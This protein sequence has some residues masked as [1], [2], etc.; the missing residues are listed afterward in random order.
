[1]GKRLPEG[2]PG[3]DAARAHAAGDFERALVLARQ[4][5]ALVGNS[6][7][8]E[9][10]EALRRLGL[11]EYELAMWREAREHLGES[12]RAHRADGTDRLALSHALDDLG[13]CCLGQ[14]E[15]AVAARH[16]QEALTLRRAQPGRADAL[17]AQSLS[18]LALIQQA[19]H[20]FAGAQALLEEALALETAA[21]VD[22]A[23][24]GTTVGNLSVLEHERGDYEA[25]FRHGEL[26]LELHLAALGPAHPTVARD[27]HNLAL[28]QSAL[29]DH[30]GA[31]ARLE[32]AL[33]VRRSCLGAEHPEVVNSQDALAAVLVAAGDYRAVEELARQ[34]F[35]SV[36]AS[37]EMP[38]ETGGRLLANL[39]HHLHQLGRPDEAVEVNTRALAVLETAS[40]RQ[41]VLRCQ[42]LGNLGNVLAD[43]DRQ[44]EAEECY[45]GG[46]EA[47]DACWP[48]PSVHRG[49]IWL[50]LANLRYSRGELAGALDALDEADRQFAC[51]HRVGSGPRLAVASSRAAILADL[52][53]RDE[54][55]RLY[56]QVVRSR[57]LGAE[58]HPDLGRDLCQLAALLQ[59]LDQLDEAERLLEEACEIFEAAL[60]GDHLAL[61]DALLY[62]AALHQRRGRFGAAQGAAARAAAVR[63]AVLGEGHPE[64]TEVLALEA[65]LHEQL[66]D[67]DACVAIRRRLLSQMEGR[68]VQ[69]DPERV[70]HLGQ[71]ADLQLETGELEAA[72]AT[73]QARIALCRRLH[74]PTDP[75]TA[76]A[77]HQHAVVCLA[78]GDADAAGL[79]A[80]EACRLLA[81]QLGAG[82]GDA[83]SALETQALAAADGGD[84][85]S[86]T[87]LLERLVRGLEETRGRWCPEI[88][89]P[90]INLALLEAARDAP[91]AAFGYLRE[92]VAVS[93]RVRLDVFS[94]AS[95]ALRAAHIAELR[96]AWVTWLRLLAL[97]PRVDP[98][99]MREA[100]ELTMRR[101][102]IGLESLRL[103]QAALG[104]RTELAPAAAAYEGVRR[105]LAEL[106]LAQAPEAELAALAAERD[107][108]EMDLARQIPG[109][110]LAAR[111]DA[112]TLEAVQAALPP[113]SALVEYV[114]TGDEDGRLLAFCL[115]EQL[116]FH[117][118][119]PMPDVETQITALRRDLQ[120]RLAGED[121]RRAIDSMAR[122][123]WDQLIGPLE[124]ALGDVE[125]LFVSAD[126][127]LGLLPFA[128]LRSPSGDSLLDRWLLVGINGPRD[129]LRFSE[130]SERPT[131]QALV[132][133][134]PDFGR[135]GDL[136]RL[137]RTAE[138]AASVAALVGGACWL[139]GDALKGRVRRV[140]GP[141]ILHIASHGIFDAPQPAHGGRWRHTAA[142][143]PEPGAMMRSGI[144]L[145][146]ANGWR[147]GQP[148]SGDVED[149]ILRAEDV[150]S[151]NL[152]STQL[153][154]LSA[155]DSGVGD[156]LV[157][158]GVFGLRR[159]VMAAGAS[160]L[161]MT[162]WR[163]ADEAARMFMEHLYA[164]L[165]AGVPRPAAL[166][167]A[168]LA[169]RAELDEPAVWGAFTYLGRPDSL[170]VPG[171]RE[172]LRPPLPLASPRAR[173]R[174]IRASSR[175]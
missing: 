67:L 78:A 40:E 99:V 7:G 171:P 109:L 133:A 168:Q 153:V 125:Q 121:R 58:A 145:A 147:P 142:P 115:R 111:L 22:A 175:G 52:G 42:V 27:L 61:A 104:E 116:T 126:G 130:V 15:L 14:G 118:L 26:A 160:G 91:E 38:A 141:W 131:T 77:I 124:G 81:Q 155:C 24:R 93:E 86:A 156:V 117:D 166:R 138:E 167:Q 3:D 44:T 64:V 35:A 5:L 170:T 31:R 114:S 123:L 122:A 21:G 161:V 105:R 39:A 150:I 65:S 102:A 54:A 95:D 96:L 136:E 146:G 47:A 143:A 128:V 59:E 48:D 36:E 51:G 110:A 53:R 41:P 34:I 70:A 33:A 107:A 89:D 132:V 32:R 50:G 152:R 165:L 103:R 62:L 29:G 137:P 11:I 76:Q 69:T 37:R 85:D 100:F 10:A 13:G 75:R 68:G 140:E 80:Q 66:G 2:K 151:M 129:L 106:F 158:E 101:K 46:L 19:R 148:L 28:A 98:S 134:D 83:L 73:C 9:R 97:Y 18:N 94:F 90:L 25:A 159:A 144:A 8:W 56:R 135:G 172:K 87:S 92:A 120:A 45:L 108:L 1:M 79:L 74:G 23:E 149:G 88:V 55:V 17:V 119:G 113:R 127:L 169:L 173:R 30:A 84:F 16:F 60:D 49:P 57:R 174:R 157:G 6:D 72:D 12:V 4:D 112:A 71:L 154:V 20:D 63:R 162:L 82:H 163:V 164:A 43:L 139:G